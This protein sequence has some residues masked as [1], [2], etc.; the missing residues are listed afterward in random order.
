MGLSV[1]FPL[2]GVV[3]FPVLLIMQKA[4]VWQGQWA[5]KPH[6]HHLILELDE[7]LGVQFLVV[8]IFNLGILVFF[9]KI[10]SFQTVSFFFI[11]LFF[12]I[13][14]STFLKILITNIYSGTIHMYK[15][16]KE[17]KQKIN[18]NL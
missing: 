8:S 3:V 17:I 2:A 5:V 7:L 9:Y 13:A 10:F 1:A 12:F 16:N 11:L 14:L 4:N 18:L 6:C 15:Q